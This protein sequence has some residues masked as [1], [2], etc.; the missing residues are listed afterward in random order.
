MSLAERP[1]ASLPNW[2]GEFD[3][4]RTLF[5]GVVSVGMKYLTLNQVSA[6]SIPAPAA[7]FNV[8]QVVPDVEAVLVLQFIVRHSLIYT[9]FSKSIVLWPSGKAA[10]LQRDDRWFESTQDYRD[11]C[12]VYR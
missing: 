6:G 12:S 8:G 4:R 5:C 1:G 3:S 10:L 7:L 9:I 11:I 2:I